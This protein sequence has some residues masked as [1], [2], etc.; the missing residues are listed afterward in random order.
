M[1]YE[2]M[3]TLAEKKN[4]ETLGK[5]MATWWLPSVWMVKGRQTFDFIQFSMFSWTRWV[6]F[7][8]PLNIDI[9]G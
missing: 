1:T 2:S 9:Y 5:A 4:Y 7:I 6:S 3:S 8:Q